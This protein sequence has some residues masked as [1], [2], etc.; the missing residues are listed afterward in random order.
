MRDALASIMIPE[1]IFAQYYAFFFITL[2]VSLF[3]AIAV[4]TT[5]VGQRREPKLGRPA[6][7]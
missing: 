7:A 2:I 1:T 3:G 6:E 4:A 5:D